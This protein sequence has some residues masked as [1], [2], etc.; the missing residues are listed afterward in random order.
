MFNETL[1]A[2]QNEGHDHNAFEFLDNSERVN[3]VATANGVTAGYGV[4]VIYGHEESGAEHVIYIGKSGKILRNGSMGDQGVRQRLGMK[5][6]GEYRDAFF[7]K[8]IRGETRHV[9]VGPYEKLRIEWIETYKD[10]KGIPPFLAEARL[11]AA[12]LQEHC[13]L[14]V[15]NREARVAECTKSLS[16][17]LNARGPTT[18]HWRT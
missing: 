14:P 2:M 1:K 5:Q 8:V 3:A 11:L 4:Y 7:R 12:Y 13:G 6:E 18:L 10:K 17:W 15:L 9:G 16:N